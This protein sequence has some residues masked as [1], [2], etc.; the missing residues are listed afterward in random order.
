M[1]CIILEST[2]FGFP[3]IY[4]GVAESRAGHAARLSAEPSCQCVVEEKRVL[5]CSENLHRFGLLI[6][7]VTA[8][9]RHNLSLLVLYMKK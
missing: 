1:I 6:V 5:Y 7:S 4:G 8:C 3:F 2:L 9:T